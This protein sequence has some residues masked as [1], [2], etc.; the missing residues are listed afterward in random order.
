MMAARQ[1]FDVAHPPQRA[2]DVGTVRV[3]VRLATGRNEAVKGNI[4]RTVT[5]RRAKVSDV[6]AAILAALEGREP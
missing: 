3:I 2:D 5:V 4:Q 1:R 6:H